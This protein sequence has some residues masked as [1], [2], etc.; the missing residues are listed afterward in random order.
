M[1][2]SNKLIPGVVGK[3]DCGK[4]VSPDGIFAESIKFAHHSLQYMY[5]Y[6]IVNIAVH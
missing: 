1:V 4:S 2:I 5:Y 3:L 6:S